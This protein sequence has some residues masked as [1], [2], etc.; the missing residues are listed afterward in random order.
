MRINTL[1]N[2]K[3]L[4]NRAA[5]GKARRRSA[6]PYMMAAFFHIDEEAL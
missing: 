2:G 1:R 5:T 6:A 3:A 4:P